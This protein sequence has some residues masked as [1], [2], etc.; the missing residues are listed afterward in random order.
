MNLLILP[1]TGLSALSALSACTAPSGKAEVNT[2]DESAVQNARI[3]EAVD[4]LILKKMDE[5][6]IPGLA[7]AIVGE[8]GV[9]WS[10]GYGLADVE[11]GLPVRADTPFMLASVSKT[12]A[13]TA[14]MRG[15]EAG[16]LSLDDGVAALTGEAVENPDY[17]ADITLRQTLSHT[18]SIIDAP[19]AWS[20]YTDGDSPIPLGSF[21]SSLLVEGGSRY[22][23][24]SYGGWAPGRLAEYSN[25]GLSTAAWALQSATGTDFAE[26]TEAEVF[27]PL[28]MTDSHWHL[29]DFDDPSRLAMPHTTRD[30][31]NF[32]ATGHYGY[33]DY[34]DGQL[35][36]PVNDLG[37][38]VAMMIG[39]GRGIDGEQVLSAASVAEM[40]RVQSDGVD[41]DQGLIWYYMSTG[42]QRVIGHEGE[43]EGVSTILFY[44]PEEGRGVIILMNGDWY[45]SGAVYDIQNALYEAR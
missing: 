16:A 31:V 3:S 37:R 35:R 38:L 21:L 12:L 6:R 5:A 9:V 42:G 27:G 24:R 18:S 39:D 8:E 43:D 34:P 28:G 45:D 40:E 26:Y 23:G 11:A 17:P 44:G 14:V 20:A 1:I 41:P 2:S 33:P 15:V 22:S 36:S 19:A 25:I 29:A 7:A 10:Q 4:A 13:V 30:G 32:R